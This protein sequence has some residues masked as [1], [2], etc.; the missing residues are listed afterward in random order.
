MGG[1][2]TSEGQDEKMTDEV[3]IDPWRDLQSGFKGIHFLENPTRLKEIRDLAHKLK[4]D[5]NEQVIALGSQQKQMSDSLDK[6]SAQRRITE[7]KKKISTIDTNLAGI[8]SRVEEL[9]KKS[10]SNS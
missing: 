8:V 10:K 1:R 6:L 2:S 4:A 7:L 9:V 3:V 5:F